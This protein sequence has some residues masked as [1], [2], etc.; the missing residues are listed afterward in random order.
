MLNRTRSRVALP[1]SRFVP[2]STRTCT[3]GEM[4]SVPR[5]GE[6]ALRRGSQAE[7]EY[8]RRRRAAATRLADRFR[9]PEGLD[10]AALSE[11]SARWLHE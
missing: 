10:H 11:A 4:P 3:R 7:A 1:D 2:G 5:E 9:Q 8:E 6:E